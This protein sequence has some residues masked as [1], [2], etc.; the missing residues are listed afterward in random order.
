MHRQSRLYAQNTLRRQHDVQARLLF[1][2]GSAPN[3]ADFVRVSPLRPGGL[4]GDLCIGK[5]DCMHKTLFGVSTTCKH[6]CFLLL[7]FVRTHFSGNALQNVSAWL[8]PLYAEIVPR[9]QHD[10]QAR[11]FFSLGLC[12]MQNAGPGPADFV[13]VSPLRP[14]GLGEHHRIATRLY[15]VNTLRRQGTSLL[16]VPASSNLG[17][18]AYG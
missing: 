9:R 10:V 12:P 3:P 15:A 5:A 6:V 17:I 7:D 8:T 14:G 4:G 18:A 2:W 11:L 16:L 1:P 13:R